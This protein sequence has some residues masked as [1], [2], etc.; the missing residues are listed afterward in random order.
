MYRILRFMT[1]LCIVA[2]DNATDL[3]N[4]FSVSPNPFN[5]NPYLVF[6]T[7][8][9]VLSQKI[10]AQNR[11]HIAF[12]NE[13]TAGIYTIHLYDNNKI[14]GIQRCIKMGN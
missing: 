4:R 5:D 1:L 12:G 7:K 3:S 11:Q 14:I 9:T 8:N 6:D 13:L 10:T 2:T